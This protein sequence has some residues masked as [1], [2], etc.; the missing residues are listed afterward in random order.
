VNHISPRHLLPLFLVALAGGVGLAGQES[1]DQVAQR[2]VEETPT[3]VSA[4]LV[5]VVVRDRNGNP[6]RDLKA[7]DFEIYEDGVRQEIGSMTPIFRK[8]PTP[9]A[10]VEAKARPEPPPPAEAAA[11]PEEETTAEVLQDAPEIIALVF[12][13]LTADSRALAHS[14]AV[15]YLE[16]GPELA[17]NYMAVFGIDAALLP[18]QNF[19][20]DKSLIR[21]AIDEF[22][23]R[24]TSQYGSVREALSGGTGDPAQQQQVSDAL[25]GAEAAAAGG[26]PS[27]IGAVGAL[28]AQQQFSNMQNSMTQTFEALERD[29]AGYATSNA[30]MAVVNGMRAIPGRKSIVFFSEGLAIPANVQEQFR[31]VIDA[32]NRSNVSIYPMDAMGL[33]AESDISKVRDEMLATAKSNLNR[34]P[35]RDVTGTA[36]SAA[37]ERNEDLLRMDPHAGL[38]E[39]ADETGGFLIANTNDLRAGFERIESD[40]RNYYLLTYVPSNDDFDG[41]FRRIEVKVR[42]S[43]VDVH[44]RKGYFAVREVPGVPVRSYETRALARLEQLPVPNQFPVWAQALSFPEH[45]RPNLLSVVVQLPTSAITFEESETDDTAYTSDFTVLVRFKDGAEQVVDQLSQ[46][47]ELN[48]PI[49]QL[50]QARNGQVIFYRQ[51]ELSPG[52][53]TM[54]TIVFDALS[55]KASV[56]FSTVEQPDTKPADLQMS[57]LVLV[58][59]GERVAEGTASTEN[60]LFVGNTLLYPNL[61]TPLKKDADKELAFFFTAYPGAEASGKVSG[62]VELLHNAQLLAQ[63]PMEL[64][65]PDASG[66]IQQVSRL[67]IDSLAP[68][69][70]QL[71]VRVSQGDMTVA[72]STE[73]R[74][75][76]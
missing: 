58:G 69:R 72:R 50:E 30:L 70:Y 12:D 63:A 44:A 27:A 60:P 51:P 39:L 75:V 33:R 1:A 47:Y 53:Y 19:T 11:S 3:Q 28:A 67:P 10:A 34:N 25:A 66:R 9:T 65:E 24:S 71:R 14:A 45:A 41:R 68:G 20:R 49:E 7:E 23:D 26:D 21:K 59:R 6:V 8:G 17:N 74:I 37:M 13:R 38:G 5:D 57:S 22:A 48:G 42:K 15:K 2:A 40:M 55:D 16:D 76:S 54:E 31:S 18:Y 56:R 29:Q 52:V 35:T 62:T 61:G 36:M 73:F 4:I 32:A 64:G 43:G 46:H